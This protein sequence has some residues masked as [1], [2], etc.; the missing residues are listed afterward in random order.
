[1]KGILFYLSE[2]PLREEIW[3]NQYSDKSIVK[4]LSSSELNFQK[5]V[6]E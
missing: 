5:S 2:F 1:M 6:M 3:D 4:G